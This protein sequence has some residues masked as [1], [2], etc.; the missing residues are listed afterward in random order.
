MIS[1]DDVR[2]LLQAEGKDAVLVLIEGR[3]EVISGGQLES[4][5]YRGALEIV[6]RDNL[7]S[8]IGTEPSERELAEQA[9]TLDAEVSELGG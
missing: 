2:Q 1:V 4:D 5:R 9:S 7:V 6:S 8:R 3:T